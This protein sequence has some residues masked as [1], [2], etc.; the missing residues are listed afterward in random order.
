MLRVFLCSMHPSASAPFVDTIPFINVHEFAAT[1]ET[2]AATTKKT[3]KVRL[4]AAYFHLRPA[5]AG[6]AAVF[7]SGRAF[8]AWE[9]RTLQVGGSL[10]W[11]AVAEV[12]GKGEVA[13]TAAYRRH[14]DLGAAAQDV[15]AEAAPQ[16]SSL[17]VRELGAS[18]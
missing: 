17:S 13:L 12:S 3:E 10:L 18:L 11:R 9:E 4:V 7:L 8:P 14:G 16:D 1:C 5:E 6:Q 15:L 2:V